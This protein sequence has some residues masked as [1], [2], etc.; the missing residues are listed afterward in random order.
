MI[1]QFWLKRGEFV[2]NLLYTKF[3]IFLIFE[4]LKRIKKQYL[5][6]NIYN[7]VF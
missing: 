7:S 4:L 1:W 5:L 3:S 2:L 6:D